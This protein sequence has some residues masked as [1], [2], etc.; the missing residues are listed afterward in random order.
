MKK[1]AR[2]E[3]RGRLYGNEDYR[4]SGSMMPKLEEMRQKAASETGGEGLQNS[5]QT[6]NAI[7]DRNV[8]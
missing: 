4:A 2:R 6:S 5:D 8:W 3:T 7:W 1:I